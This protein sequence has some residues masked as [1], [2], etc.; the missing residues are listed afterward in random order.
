MILAPSLMAYRLDF[1]KIWS[2]SGSKHWKYVP[3]ERE[4]V[5][6]CLLMAIIHFDR[7]AEKY[8][9][10]Q[11]TSRTSRFRQGVHHLLAHFEVSVCGH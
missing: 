4:I 11:G 8:K 10:H 1:P 9:E 3:V 5:S 7:V 6:R 2:E